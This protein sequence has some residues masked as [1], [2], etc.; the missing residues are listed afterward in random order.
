MEGGRDR[1]ELVFI[2]VGEVG[3]VGVGIGVCFDFFFNMV[4]IFYLG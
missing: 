1:F 3:V 4:R 2:C